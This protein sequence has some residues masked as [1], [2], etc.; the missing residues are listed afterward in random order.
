MPIKRQGIRYD[1]NL[2]EAIE[3]N[4][5]MKALQQQQQQQQQIQ[6]TK[7]PNPD[8]QQQQPKTQSGTEKLT[9]RGVADMIN[10][11]LLENIVKPIGRHLM[12]GRETVKRQGG[13][14]PKKN[15]ELQQWGKVVVQIPEKLLVYKYIKRDRENK[16]FAYTP[17]SAH[18]TKVSTRKING[19]EVRSIKFQVE[20]NDFKPK[21]I[22]KSDK[23]GDLVIGIPSEMIHVVE[24]N[25]KLEGV[26]D[27]LTKS[28]QLS[29]VKGITSILI[30]PVLG[31]KIKVVKSQK[32][33]ED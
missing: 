7:T 26:R 18:M 9:A 16:E 1:N 28:G 17:L 29:K 32:E 8:E 22:T 21:I 6:P 13:R 11:F 14:K 5:K 33:L 23:W 4:E 2:R 27:T 10:K 20:D 19:V 12:K 3:Y 25:N 30:Q 31:N 24:K 15:E